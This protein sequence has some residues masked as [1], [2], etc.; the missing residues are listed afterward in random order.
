VD[1]RKVGEVAEAAGITVRTL[2][3]YE[4]VGLLTPRERTASGHRLYGDDEVERLYRVTQLR[5][6]GF[7]LGEIGRALDAGDRDL[8][9]VMRSQL[10]ALDARIDAATRLRSRVA[11][12]LAQS[13]PG[14]DVLLD[15]MEET[16]MLDTTPQ[17]RIGILVYRDLAAVFEHL[18]RVFGLGPGELDRTPDG[19]AVHAEIEAG[20]GVLWLHAEAPEF[21]LASPRT[22]GVATAMVAVMVDDVDAHHERAVAQGADVLEAPTD[23][24][25]GYREYT[26]RD[27][28]GGLWSFMKP[29][30]AAPAER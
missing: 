22:A 3:H 13:S 23:Q 18:I 25:Y 10:A 30:G 2:H 5:R 20:D 1:G 11:A 24:P 7:S 28:E 29:L 6:L 8:A 14:S 4:A 21:G 19:T 15:L 16:A 26:A 27:I 9:D 17:R 12:A